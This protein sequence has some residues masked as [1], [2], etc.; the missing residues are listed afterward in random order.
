M[1]LNRRLPF[2][3]LALLVLAALACNFVTG[4]LSPDDAQATADA[5]EAQSENI[6]E[7]AEAT[8]AAAE[9]TADAAQDLLNENDNAN[10]NDDN[11][12]ENDNSN[13]NA[14]ENDNGNSGGDDD[15]FDGQ[16]PEDI[17]VFT[18][19]D[20]PELVLADDASLTYNVSGS[21]L[22]E[23][24]DFYREAM[25]D[26]GWELAENGEFELGPITTLTYEQGNRTAIITLT[27]LLGEVTVAVVVQ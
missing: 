18:G 4:G 12:N 23:V 20:D 10:E 8:A 25:P 24:A 9:A 7:Q 26:E 16:G 2:I 17:P 11:G 3:V 19:A 14:N 15:P 6:G 21:T 5:I 1:P 22:D 27:D 13:D